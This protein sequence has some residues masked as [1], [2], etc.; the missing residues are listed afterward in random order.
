MKINAINNTASTSFNGLWEKSRELVKG[1][2]NSVIYKDEEWY[3]HPFADESYVS[4]KKALDSK[5]YTI[6]VPGLN[7]F[8]VEEI[9][10]EPKVLSKLSFTEKEFAEYKKFYGKYLPESM[11]KIEQELVER[12]LSK[13][14]NSKLL[15]AAKRLLHAVRII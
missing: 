12:D 3:Y 15:C 14:L 11:K 6:T 1:Y 7:D 8:E 9:T 5:R 13:Y 4:V 2:T 10:S